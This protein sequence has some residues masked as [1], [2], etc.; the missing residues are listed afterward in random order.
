MTSI[1]FAGDPH[2]NFR[3]INSAATSSKPSAVV[4]LGDYDLM[5]PLD[6]ELRPTLDAGVEVWWIHGNHDADREDWHDNL[7]SSGLK[8]FSLHGKVTTVAGIRIAGLGGTFDQ[9]VWRP[10][11]GDG[12]PLIDSRDILKQQMAWRS[13]P[14]PIREGIPIRHRSSIFWS[15]YELLFD[16]QADILVL[17]EAPDGHRLGFRVLGEL[18]E[19]MGVKAIVH[20]HH[21][22]AYQGR[23]AGGVPVLGVN[24]ATVVGLPEGWL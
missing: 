21:H 17:H 3:A 20:G 5:Q 24:R 12:K 19:A 1:L 10:D 22:E 18:A 14:G 23:T 8:D 2:G 11:M 6:N 4:L 13:N 16:Q 9:N 15:D 7:F